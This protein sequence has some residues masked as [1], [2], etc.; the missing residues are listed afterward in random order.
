MIS[1][2]NIERLTKCFRSGFP[3]YCTIT[4]VRDVSLEM[5]AGE[6]WAL[7]GLNGAGKSTLMRC[8]I[9]LQHPTAGRVALF[10]VPAS[11]STWRGKVGYLPERVCLP[12]GVRAETILRLAG[13]NAGLPGE[14]LRRRI[15]YWVDRLSLG[16]ALHGGHGL[17]KGE[18]RKICLAAILVYDPGLLV[19]DEPTDGLDPQGKHCIQDVLLEARDRGTAILMSSHQLSEVERTADCVAV[20]R[21]GCLAIAGRLG[22]PGGKHEL[23]EIHSGR[24]GGGDRGDGSPV[25]STI[26]E[27]FRRYAE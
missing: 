11:S 2:L 22:R 20:L 4:A 10:G 15:E 14:T 27:I 26:E 16:N 21:R 5:K 13:R 25:L 3:R 9:N 18:E 8:C 19:L 6:I 1:P 23:L 17:S 7:M 12:G 24:N